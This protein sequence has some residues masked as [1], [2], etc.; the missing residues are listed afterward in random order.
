[1]FVL[2]SWLALP[3]LSLACAMSCVPPPQVV[4]AHC[5]ESTPGEKMTADMSAD[6]GTAI[7][8]GHRCVDH[9]PFTVTA[10]TVHRYAAPAPA[11]PVI[12]PVGATDN[13]NGG[14]AGVSSSASATSPPDRPIIP[15]RL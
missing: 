5:H 1:L 3:V 7:G 15:L 10:T 13:A 12:V 6:G 2:T 9:A 14:P 4:A 11:M 8:V